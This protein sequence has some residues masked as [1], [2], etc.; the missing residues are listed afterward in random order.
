MKKG[1]TFLTLLSLAGVVTVITMTVANTMTTHLEQELTQKA[2]TEILKV[3]MNTSKETDKE[4]PKQTATPKP[5]A[6]PTLP[7]T[8][9][10]V[11][12]VATPASTPV[13]TPKKLHLV[14]P[15][16][17]AEV[18]N[19]YTEDVLVFQATYG[20]YRAHLGI[21]FGGEE[22]TPVYAASDG[23]VTRC[24]FDYEQGY[25][26]ELSHDDGYL[27]TYTN[28]ADDQVVSVGQVVLQ[29]DRIGTMGDSGIWESHLPCHVHFEL[30]KDGELL[31]PQDFL[32]TSLSEE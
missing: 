14:L 20:D 28:L 22:T 10:P 31:N 4:S 2:N 27:T 6:R 19:E 26:V 23:I 8:P 7:P 29:G 1:K 15:V 12:P 18:I 30:S 24:E 5:T 21:D 32:Y 11:S 3:M 13:P 16:A 9:T 17:G 25:T